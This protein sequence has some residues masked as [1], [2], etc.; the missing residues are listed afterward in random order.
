MGFISLKEY[1]N[2]NKKSEID[3]VFGAGGIAARRNSKVA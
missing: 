1:A 2:R 3:T